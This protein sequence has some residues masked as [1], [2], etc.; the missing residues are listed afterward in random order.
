MRDLNYHHLFYFWSVVREGGVLRASRKLEVAQPTVSQQLRELE[1]SLKETLFERQGRKLVLTEMGRVVYGYANEIFLLGS[2]LREAIAG[3]PT[4]RPLKLVVGLTDTLP[5]LIAFRLLEPAL[6]MPQRLRAVCYEGTVDSLVADLADH[7]VD[8]VL[9]DSLVE[10][11]AGA[12]VYGH[13]LG[14]SSVTLFAKRKRA[15]RLRPTFPK[16]LHGAPLLLPTGNTALRRAIDAWLE[17]I[18]V[19]PN[20]VGEFQD[21]ALLSEFG[22]QNV[23]VFPASSAVEEDVRWH[24]QVEVVGRIPHIRQTFYAISAERKLAHPAVVL[25]SNTARTDLFA[26]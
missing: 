24:H 9:S 11:T 18:G 15:A 10:S 1:R 21:S 16:S 22:E 12:R 25:I 4:G 19:R 20:V 3:H 14:E 26:S 17:E 23:G 2:E 5:K 7:A 6:R 13:L 8:L